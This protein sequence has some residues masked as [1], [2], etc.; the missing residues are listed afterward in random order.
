MLNYG[1]AC[2]S[3]N[4]LCENLARYSKI[5]VAKRK[6]HN[7]N[8]R[9]N[10]NGD[11]NTNQNNS[12]NESDSMSICSEEPEDDDNLNFDS[13]PHRQKGPPRKLHW[14]T[15][16]LIYCFYVKCNIS[17]KRCAALFGVGCTLVHD[18]VYSWVN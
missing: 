18:I 13:L 11:P 14:K 4:G 15:E 2:D 5:S 17:Q 9:A 16:Y 1:E 10:N 6:E 12:D 8:L 3:G 7:S